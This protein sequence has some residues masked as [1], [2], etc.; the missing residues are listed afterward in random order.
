[1]VETAEQRISSP[2]P[3]SAG[4]FGSKLAMDN[5]W[6]FIASQ[7]GE[8]L[9]VYQYVLGSWQHRQRIERILGGNIFGYRVAIEGNLAAVVEKIPYQSSISIWTGA[10]HLF[11]LD[12]TEEWQLISTI[13]SPTA[14]EDDAFGD[15]V[16]I[17]NGTLYVGA[18]DATGASGEK[19]GKVYV[20]EGQ[21]NQWQQT[22]ELANPTD[23]AGED[24]GA[25]LALDGINLVVGAPEVFASGS[26]HLYEASGP[27]WVHSAEIE[28]PV[29]DNSSFASS[30]S[31]DGGTLVVG[32]PSA[33]YGDLASGSAYVYTESNGAWSFT[34]ELPR[35]ATYSRGEYGA[36]LVV[37]DDY[38]LVGAPREWPSSFYEEQGTAYFYSR[39]GNQWEEAAVIRPAITSSYF[40]FD[41]H[42]GTQVSMDQNKA[43]IGSPGMQLN[44]G[45]YDVGYVFAYS[46]N[47]LTRG[48]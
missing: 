18:S 15:S 8:P 2:E 16:L 36:D 47:M 1:M 6:A 46:T 37:V 23:E 7:Y 40:S 10:V 29:S 4:K 9:Q 42:F 5:D 41:A 28:S 3:T 13:Y 34:Q 30:L 48:R 31:I 11:E 17:D 20:Y 39:N 12:A 26:F 24:F 43:L 45:I 33:L 32:A 38:I 44:A 22:L 21:D 35:S 19:S 14:Q 25:S 27:A